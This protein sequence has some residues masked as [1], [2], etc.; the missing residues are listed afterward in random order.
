LNF[1]ADFWESVFKKPFWIRRYF[2]PFL[3]VGAAIN[4][5]QYAVIS[6]L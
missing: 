4:T 6:F 1:I 2:V 3:L 5:V